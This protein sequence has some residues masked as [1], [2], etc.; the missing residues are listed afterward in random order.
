MHEI[1]P[2]IVNN[3]TVNAAVYYCNKHSW[4]M[5]LGRPAH[6]FP[7]NGCTYLAHPLNFQLSSLMVACLRTSLIFFIIEGGSK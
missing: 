2:V 7:P 5:L 1:V 4:R 6:I 3:I